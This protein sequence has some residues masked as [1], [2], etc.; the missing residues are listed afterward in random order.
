[1][2]TY[3]VTGTLPYREHKPGE[4]FETT[5]DEATERRAL[6]RR[7]I[8]IVQHTKVGLEPGSWRL[9]RG[10]PEPIQED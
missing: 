10:W 9:P 8:R 3:Q 5:L 6:A 2:T 4:L 1:M 7:N